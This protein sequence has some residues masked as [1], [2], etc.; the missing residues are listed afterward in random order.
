[1]QNFHVC[2][3]TCAEMQA[4]STFWVQKVRLICYGMMKQV[5]HLGYIK[6]SFI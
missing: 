3:K 6:F 5:L 2:M 4:I 1:M